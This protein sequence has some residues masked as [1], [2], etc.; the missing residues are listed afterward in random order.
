MI[1]IIALCLVWSAFVVASLALAAQRPTPLPEQ[2][3][4]R[5]AT[6][7]PELLTQL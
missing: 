1:L 6:L 7:N 3:N 2:W 5:L 4:P